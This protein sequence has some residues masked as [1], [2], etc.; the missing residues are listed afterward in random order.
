MSGLLTSW[1][2]GNPEAG[3]RLFSACYQELR[4]LARHQLRRRPMDGTL[5]TTALIHELYLK[6]VDGV[7]S[8]LRNRGHFMAL[9]SRVMRQIVVDYARR[10]QTVKRGG[11]LL[12]PLEEDPPFSR[13]TRAE[14]LVALDQALGKLEEL[15][16]R[17]ARLVDLRFFGGLS[18]DETAEALEISVATVKR[19]WLRARAFLFQQMGPVPSP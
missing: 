13:G 14:D 7:R 9:A 5:D 10:K 1:L 15:D 12:Q 17:L 18:N 11:A 4:R 16:P 19:D 3:D 2:E 8:P 6:M